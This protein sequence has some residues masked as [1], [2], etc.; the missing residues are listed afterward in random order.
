M[1]GLILLAVCGATVLL[2]L[3][4]LDVVRWGLRAYEK[5][6]LERGSQSLSQM[7]IFVDRRQLLTWT[8]VVSI[9]LGVLG[10]VL[11][12][13][14]FALVLLAGGLFAPWIVIKRLRERRIAEFDRQL[15]DALTQMGAALRAGL[16]FAQAADS[17][18]QEFAPPLGEEFKLLVREVKLGVSQDDALQNLADRIASDSLRLVVT[19][20][21]ISKQLGGNMAEIYD[22]IAQTVRDRFQTE[23]RVRALT[24]M[25]RMQ[26]WIIG[27]MPVVMGL[28]LNVIRPDMMEPMLA[29][30]FGKM[31][32]VVVVVMEVIG[33][34]LIRRMV[35][36]DF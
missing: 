20:T 14:L 11:F 36:I 7:F 8:V 18:A 30:F 19:A 31:L 16:S 25:G 35:N 33:V 5:R 23:G 12:N 4:L 21:T 27:A 6:Y 3:I 28:A 22:V 32:I 15:V 17:I 1:I 29:A 13:W 9:V 2:A 26:A 24:A 10:F 34:L